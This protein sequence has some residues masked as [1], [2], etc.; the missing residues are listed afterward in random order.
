MEK[1]CLF[2]RF[3]ESA[4]AHPDAVACQIKEGNDYQTFTYARLYESSLRFAA[5]L[6]Q[7]GLAKGE[8]IAILLENSPF[9][10]AIYFGIIGIGDRKSV[11]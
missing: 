4:K 7:E 11:V 8:R 1:C 2:S 5:L 9:W 6:K 10:P 3:Q